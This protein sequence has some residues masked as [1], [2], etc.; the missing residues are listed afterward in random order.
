MPEE[1]K[2]KRGRPVE[3]KPPEP[4]PDTP[5]NVIK[6]LLRTRTRAERA[7]LKGRGSK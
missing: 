3:R 4:I 2:R 6:S 1:F 7:R 5:E